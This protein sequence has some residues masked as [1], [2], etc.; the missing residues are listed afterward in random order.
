MDLVALVLEKLLAVC[1]LDPLEMQ[2]VDYAVLDEVRQVVGLGSK[3][4]GGGAGADGRIAAD[5]SKETDAGGVVQQG[6]SGGETLL[7]AASSGLSGL[8]SKVSGASSKISG[9]S[10]RTEKEEEQVGVLST[11]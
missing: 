3:R 8:S 10:S 5:G 7:G 2:V 11:F 4:G 1:N 6:S 9:V